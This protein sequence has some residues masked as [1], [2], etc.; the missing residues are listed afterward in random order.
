M[1]SITQSQTSFAGGGMS[2]QSYEQTYR[3]LET[4]NMMTAADLAALDAREDDLDLVVRDASGKWVFRNSFLDWD[5]DGK[6]NAVGLLISSTGRGLAVAGHPDALGIYDEDAFGNI[7]TGTLNQ[8]Y[9]VLL[10][11]ARVSS[12]T[13]VT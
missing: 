5:G 1:K 10:N 4:P 8:S 13:R 12:E 2:L 11:T 3:Y 7:T 9:S 6:I